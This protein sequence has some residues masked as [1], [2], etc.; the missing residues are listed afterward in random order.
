MKQSFTN[1]FTDLL[2][3]AGLDQSHYDGHGLESVLHPQQFVWSNSGFF[4]VKFTKLAYFPSYI[5]VDSLVWKTY[6]CITVHQQTKHFLQSYKVV[7]VEDVLDS[8]VQKF[9]REQTAT[10]VL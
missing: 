9:K 10:I 2:S 3:Q 1:H 5:I 8:L 7:E 4:R 6:D